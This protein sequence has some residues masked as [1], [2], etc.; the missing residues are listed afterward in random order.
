MGLLQSRR[1]TL[2]SA[3]CLLGLTG[4]GLA[5]SGCGHRRSSVIAQRQ[6][7][8][9]GRHGVIEA[10]SFGRTDDP[11]VVMIPSLGRGAQDFAM[12]AHAV[13]AHGF[14]VVCPQPRGFAGSAAYAPKA[15]LSDLAD[16]VIDVILSVARGPVVILG[17]AFGNRVARM[18]ATARPDL[19]RALI[20]LAAGGKVAMAPEIEQALLAS[21]DLSLPDDVRMQAVARAFF[22]PG[23]NAML[24]RDG[25]RRDVAEA[26]IAAT[27]RTPV[28]AWWRAGDARILVIQPMQDVL[29]PAENAERLRA[30]A[31]DR[32]SVVYV[33]QAGHALLP[34]QPGAVADAVIA[35]LDTLTD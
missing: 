27:E 32:V 15:D 24:W 31:P 25:W 2:S 28:D 12:L 33:D 19:V 17:H 10:H 11:G 8:I 3:L 34:E 13:A 6:I 18:C 16:D 29:A 14:H 22:A 21:F 23:N 7:V 4:A 1:A 35:F 9:P 20:L 30:S 26:Q 5:T